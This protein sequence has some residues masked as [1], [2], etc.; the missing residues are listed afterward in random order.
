MAVVE[1]GGKLQ[2]FPVGGLSRYVMVK[3]GETTEVPRK[4]NKEQDTLNLAVQETRVNK[5]ALGSRY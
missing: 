5:D 4:G 2:G 1:R 3:A